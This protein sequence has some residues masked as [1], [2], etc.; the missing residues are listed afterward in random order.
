MKLVRE[1]ALADSPVLPVVTLCFCQ[2]S[3]SSTLT[4][5]PFVCGLFFKGFLNAYRLKSVEVFWDP[6]EQLGAPRGCFS[7][8]L[9][10]PGGNTLASD[11]APSLVVPQPPAVFLGTHIP[12]A[13]WAPTWPWGAAHGPDSGP[14][15]KCSCSGP[16]AESPASSPPTTGNQLCPPPDSATRKNPNSVSHPRAQVDSGTP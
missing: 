13:R 5:H 14:G 8:Q 10:P 6:E 3:A 16:A 1:R 12:L 7:T 9:R 11:T 4:V 2:H 15:S